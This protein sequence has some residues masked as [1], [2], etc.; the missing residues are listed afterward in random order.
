MEYMY[1]PVRMAFV[2]S[3]AVVLF[4]LPP[5]HAKKTAP[6]GEMKMEK[7]EIDA[8]LGGQVPL[9]TPF[10]DESGEQVTLG[11]LLK[12][13]TLLTL[14]YLTCQHACP[15]LLNGVASLIGESTLIPGKDYEVVTVSF[16]ETDTPDLAAKKKGNYVKAVGKP[17]PPGAWHFLTGNRESIAALTGAVGFH[18]KRE[19]EGFTHPVSLIVLSK[20]GKIIRYLDG[21]DF[22]PFDLEMAVTEATEGRIGSVVRRAILYCFSYDPKGKKYVF[23][24]LKV[25]GI[26]SV[27]VAIGMIAFLVITGRKYRKGRE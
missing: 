3:A 15:R 12:K 8:K 11:S 17:F 20:E 2:V 24:I 23:D 16:D 19:R 27:M 7:V 6:M 22:L 5:A 26:V 13:P 21:I 10:F 25:V 18:F 1:L 9:E 14:V 4:C